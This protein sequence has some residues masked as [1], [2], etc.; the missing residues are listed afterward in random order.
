MTY[1]KGTLLGPSGL[2]LCVLS[3]A[4]S[5]LSSSAVSTLPLLSRAHAIYHQILSIPPSTLRPARRHYSTTA[6]LNQDTTCSHP[7]YCSLPGAVLQREAQVQL[8]GALVTGSSAIQFSLRLN[9]IYQPFYGLPESPARQGLV[10]L[11]TPVTDSSDTL[12]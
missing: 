4:V 3:S 8:K 11:V 1:S 5:L 12:L 7:G 10:T 2:S 9:W 6:G